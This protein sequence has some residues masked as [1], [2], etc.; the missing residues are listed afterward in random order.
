VH[1]Q[2]WQA[3]DILIVAAAAAR[4]PEAHEAALVRLACGAAALTTAAFL[5]GLADAVES[6]F[7]IVPSG[8]ELCLGGVSARTITK[9]ILCQ[10][11]YGSSFELSLPRPWHLPAGT[12]PTRALR[13]NGP[14][15]PLTTPI[16]QGPC[17]YEPYLS[18][19]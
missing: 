13:A 12:L 14:C 10:D 8:L 18:R 7:G 17:I 16:L 5:L 6:R 19:P 3:V 4:E 9:R 1:L 2:H 15:P 11:T